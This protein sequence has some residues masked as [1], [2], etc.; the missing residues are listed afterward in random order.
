MKG[1]PNTGFQEQRRKRL[2]WLANYLLQV[3]GK[4]GI[5]YGEVRAILLNKWGLTS[6]KTDEYLQIVIETHGFELQ[7]GR[8]VK[9]QNG[10]I[11]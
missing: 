9:T 10:Q 4:D 5:R 2:E 8:I 3:V 6:E 11:S 7:E 1:E